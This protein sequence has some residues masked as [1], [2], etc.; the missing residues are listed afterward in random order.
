MRFIY[1]PRPIDPVRFSHL[2]G[3]NGN[4]LGSQV[5]LANSLLKSSITLGL[6]PGSVDQGFNADFTGT[7]YTDLLLYNRQQG[8]LDILTFSDRFR[9]T[10]S[11]FAHLTAE[12]Q[13]MDNTPQRV[14]LS[15]ATTPING[16]GSSLDIHIGDFTGS[17]RSE[18]LLNDRV[19]GTLQL[20]SLTPQLKIQKH[21]TLPGWGPDWELYVGQFDGQHSSVF[22]YNPFAFPNPITTPVPMPSPT[23][24]N[25][26]GPTT[27]QTPTPTPTPSPTPS[28]SPSPTPTPTPTPSPTP[29]PSPSPT[30]T[31][32]PT[33]SPTPSPS[34]S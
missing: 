3:M 16:W 23:A 30:P 17:G 25:Q 2:P 28:P 11:H 32:T 33:P 12:Y 14:S 15:D 7:G 13:P 31:P 4:S 21:V 5:N 19:T 1:F 22:M 34:P 26:P 27:G 10:R 9:Q 18:I 8:R 24:G 6:P 29:S 20:I